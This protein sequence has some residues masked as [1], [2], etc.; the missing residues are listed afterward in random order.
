[1]RQGGLPRSPRPRPQPPAGHA[2]PDQHRS[3]CH[4][5]P[6]FLRH[7]ALTRPGQCRSRYESSPRAGC[8]TPSG[9]IIRYG[10]GPYDKTGAAGSSSST[11]RVCL[12]GSLEVHG[13]LGRDHAPRWLAG[14]GERPV[15]RDR[16]GPRATPADERGIAARIAAPDWT[17]T[18]TERLT[19]A[20]VAGSAPA[21][22]TAC[23]DG[24]SG[25]RLV[26]RMRRSSP[27]A[28]SSGLAGHYD[29]GVARPVPE[30]AVGRTARQQRPH[31]PGEVIKAITK[32]VRRRR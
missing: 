3:S 28:K 14:R 20:A 26:A 32:Q 21:D 25:R 6:G 29:L 10:S 1:M 17:D 8:T 7:W 22:L 18:G 31:L 15:E 16:D 5:L 27:F 30:N 9:A 12:R 4:P 2:R 19:T 23:P 11:S 24:A 13:R